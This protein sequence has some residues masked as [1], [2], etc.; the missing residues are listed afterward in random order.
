MIILTS[1]LSLSFVRGLIGKFRTPCALHNHPL[2]DPH[3]PMRAKYLVIRI[4]L[5]H[6]QNQAYCLAQILNKKSR[7]TPDLQ[8]RAPRFSGVFDIRDMDAFERIAHLI[9]AIPKTKRDMKW[10][11]LSD[12]R[13]L[14]ITGKDAAKMRDMEQFEDDEVLPDDGAMDAANRHQEA[15]LNNVRPQSDLLDPSKH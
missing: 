8:K 14:F 15:L 7:I 11:T 3:N 13:T 2:W 4:Q 10:W 12:G 1:I 9:P 5:R 6:K